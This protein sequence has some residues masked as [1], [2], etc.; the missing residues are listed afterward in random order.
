MVVHVCIIIFMSSEASHAARPYRMRKRLE[1]FEGTRRRIVEAT[2][3]LHGSVGPRYT[4]IKGVASK[5]GVQRS[6]VYRHF[7]DEETLY[8][9][10]TSHWFARHPWP[11]TEDWRDEPDPATRLARG[12]GD[13]YRYY[14]ENEQMMSNS[15]RDVA[16]MPPF[17]GELLR[18]QLENTHAALVEAWSRPD[19]QRVQIAVR[20]AV[21]F[22]TWA[23]LASNGLGPAAASELMTAMIVGLTD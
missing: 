10:C 8:G 18:A 20:H 5:A 6:T 14:D 7:P 15:F 19:D 11:R 4:T 2:V 3:E 16:I 9:A 12:L 1:D 23:S 21:D 17:V 13:L 22:R